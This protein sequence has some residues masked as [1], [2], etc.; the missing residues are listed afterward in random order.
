VQYLTVQPDQVVFKPADTMNLTGK[1]PWIANDTNS[2]L[3][4]LHATA[5]N[6]VEAVKNEGQGRVTDRLHTRVFYTILRLFSGYQLHGSSDFKLIDRAVLDAYLSLT[7]RGLFFRGLTTWLGFRHST[8]PFDIPIRRT[9][10]SKWSS[11]Q[12][13][14]LALDAMTTFSS[15]PLRLITA[16]GTGFLL[17]AIVIGAQT[18][19]QKL[20][21]NAV[22]GFTTVIL[23]LLIIGSAIM[24]GLGIIGEYIGRIYDEVK[25]RPRFIIERSIRG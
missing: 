3:E 13:V 21:G 6:V 19:F 14:R 20:S 10:S 25:H 8:I 17:F 1:N 5:D 15:A 11:W 18:L 22:D 23:L 4:Q 16:L 12:L 2:S 9:G 24:V 7:E